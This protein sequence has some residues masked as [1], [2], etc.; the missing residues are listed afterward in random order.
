MKSKTNKKKHKDDKSQNTKEFKPKDLSDIE[1]P[2]RMDVLNVIVHNSQALNPAILTG[3][4]I[5]LLVILLIFGKI[6]VATTFLSG[7]GYTAGRIVR[8]IRRKKECSI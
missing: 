4:G 3:A 7:I 2:T 5:T 8:R 6:M 1:N